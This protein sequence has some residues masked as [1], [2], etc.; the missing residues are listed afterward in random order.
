MVML[1]LFGNQPGLIASIRSERAAIDLDESGNVRVD[2]LDEIRNLAKIV[3]G[4]F[5]ITT[6]GHREVNFPANAGSVSNVIQKKSH[7][8]LILSL[9]FV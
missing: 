8:P 3:T 9:I 1:N 6:E 7:T 5:K 2:R 4:V